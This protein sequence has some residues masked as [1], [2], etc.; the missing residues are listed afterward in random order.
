MKG[1]GVVVVEESPSRMLQSERG[2]AEWHI[3][4]PPITQSRQKIAS[5]L[6][7]MNTFN[8]QSGFEHAERNPPHL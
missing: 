7:K 3:Q 6:T 5:D 8:I 2:V 4:A 1:D